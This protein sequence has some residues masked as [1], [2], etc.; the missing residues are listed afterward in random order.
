L[1]SA[2]DTLLAPRL[3]HQFR[4]PSLS[5][6]TRA[7]GDFAGGSSIPPAGLH[8]SHGIPA[9]QLQTSARMLPPQFAGRSGWFS[10]TQPLLSQIEQ[11]TTVI[12][13]AGP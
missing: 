10:Q 1:S 3:G 2:A 9:P 11:R 7:I 8:S 13:A 4:G 12:A 6:V 5:F